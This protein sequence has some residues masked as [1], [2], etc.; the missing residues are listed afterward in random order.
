MILPVNDVVF[1]I[2]T[3]DEEYYSIYGTDIIMSPDPI[4]WRPINMN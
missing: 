3:G 4:K 1:S 2:T